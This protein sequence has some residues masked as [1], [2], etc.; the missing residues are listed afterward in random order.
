MTVDMGLPMTTP[1]DIPVNFDAD[2]MLDAPIDVAGKRVK[3][4]AVSMGNPH[5]VVF[6]DSFTDEMVHTLGQE[7]EKHEIWPERANIE[8]ARTDDKNTLSVRAWERGVGE[9]MACGTGACAAATAAVLTGRAD[10]P[11]TVRLL[12]GNMLIDRDKATGHILM[13]GPAATLHSGTYY[14]NHKC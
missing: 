11:I 4:T 9:T 6:V 2:A 7:L 8:F 5:G 10:W 3:V 13:T 1:S 12:G 14:A